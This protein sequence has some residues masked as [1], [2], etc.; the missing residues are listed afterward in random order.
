MKKIKYSEITPENIYKNR[1]N[2][3][4]NLGLAAGSM[5]L[6][7]NLITSANANI[8]KEDLKLTEYRYVT[9]YNNYYEFGTGKSDPFQNSQKFKTKP[10]DVVI[11]GEVEKPLKLVHLKDNDLNRVLLA[12]GMR[13]IIRNSLRLENFFAITDFIKF[14]IQ[15]FSR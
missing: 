7:Q 6:S 5:F 4:K 15:K 10:W 14:N 9:T 12:P 13:R 8:E 2:F 1:R 11:D 3:I